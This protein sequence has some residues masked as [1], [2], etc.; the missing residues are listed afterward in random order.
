MRSTFIKIYPKFK[1]GKIP[2]LLLP[3]DANVYGVSIVL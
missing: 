2:S 1:G 3:L